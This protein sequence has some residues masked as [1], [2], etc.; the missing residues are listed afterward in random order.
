MINTETTIHP[1]LEHLAITTGHIDAMIGWY[2][3]VIGAKLLH[4]SANPTGAPG[5][6][7]GITAA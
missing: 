5:G 1:Y 2:A 6:G 4:R 3:T 7:S